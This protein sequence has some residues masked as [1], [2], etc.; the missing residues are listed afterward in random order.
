MALGSESPEGSQGYTK[1]WP[2]RQQDVCAFVNRSEND[3]G[4]VMKA[5]SSS[6]AVVWS[7][8]G[9]ISVVL[10]GLEGRWRHGDGA[11]L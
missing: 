1:I 10:R 9:R 4:S 7:W 11:G 8:L 3:A 5:V 6:S 2:R